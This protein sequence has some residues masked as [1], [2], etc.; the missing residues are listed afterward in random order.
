MARKATAAPGPVPGRRAVVA[1]DGPLLDS[2]S[3]VVDG[4]YAAALKPSLWPSALGRIAKLHGC[5]AVHLLTPVIAPAQGG[6][7]CSHGFSAD[8]IDFWTRQALAPST[9]PREGAFSS[10]REGHVFLSDEVSPGVDLESTF[11]YL[12]YLRRVGVGSGSYCAGVVFDGSRRDLVAT[13]CALFHGSEGRAFTVQDKNLHRLTIRHLSRALGTMYRLRDAE[14]KVAAS[15]AALDGL[16]TG[17]VLLGERGNAL[18]ANKSAMRVLAAGDG[19]RL[20]TGSLRGDEMGWLSAA[21]PD[22]QRRLE[23]GIRE[24]CAASV[25][26]RTHFSTGV[27][28]R[29][30]GGRHP[31]LVQ[32]AALAPENDF[33]VGRSNACAIAFIGEPDRIPRLDVSLLARAFGLTHAE[34]LLAQELVAGRGLHAAARELGISANTA[35][36]QLQ[37]IFQKTHTSRQAELARLLMGAA[38]VFAGG[39]GLDGAGRAAVISAPP[40]DDDERRLAMRGASDSVISVMVVLDVATPA[41]TRDT[42]LRRD[43]PCEPTTVTVGFAPGG[44]TD[45][46]ARIVAKKLADNIGQPVAVEN[47]TG[48]SGSA[49]WEYL[50]TAKPDG[51]TLHVAGVEGLAVSSVT[52]PDLLYKPLNDFAPVIM[53]AISPIIY[54]VPGSFTAR[55]LA[56]FL[57]LAKARP[58]ELSYG[59]PGATTTNHLAGA[60]LATR[61]GVTLRHIP[62]KGGGPA[63]V[64]LLGGRLSMYPAQIPTSKLHVQAGR[65][66]ALATAGATR[67]ALMPELPAVAELGYP[68]FDVQ[69]SYAFFASRRVPAERLDYWN[70]EIARVLADP[71]VRAQLA[72]QGLEAAGGSRQELGAYLSSQARRWGA[73]I[74]EGK[75]KLD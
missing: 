40:R 34:C 61:A 62:Y 44:A 33:L 55:T 28:I 35:K 9:A 58:G 41:R 20:R 48:G 22:D 13:S 57:E 53:G 46:F 74:R 54:V 67:M 10:L 6:L 70:R 25:F 50:A 75:I 47:R 2:F 30:S 56:E 18:F 11:F 37:S 8:E 31:L 64:D 69:T 65:L 59:S 63:M 60:L 4:I 7:V 27:A 15:M 1:T 26:P 71:E 16:A 3:E 24:A 29:R 72:E 38:S 73:L 12:D 66:R 32:L 39:F 45:I 42:H 51:Y 49:G 19:I 21:Q 17:V 14:M 23:E 43:F 36:T 52:R 5:P 68:G